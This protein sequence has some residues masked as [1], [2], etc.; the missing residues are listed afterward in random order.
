[1]AEFSFE[2]S[3]D[4]DAGGASSP[5]RIHEK[6]V[7]GCTSATSTASSWIR[8]PIRRA[9]R[10]ND[11]G[12]ADRLCQGLASRSGQT[13]TSRAWKTSLAARSPGCW[14][15]LPLRLGYC[16]A[17]DARERPRWGE[18]PVCGTVTLSRVHFVHPAPASPDASS[19]GGIRACRRVAIRFD[20]R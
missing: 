2:T 5:R 1:V 9:G 11:G 3:A 18:L 12:F 16:V 6:S 8:V 13:Q 10:P 4:R 14:V 15:P 7:V 20:R 19:A 17:N